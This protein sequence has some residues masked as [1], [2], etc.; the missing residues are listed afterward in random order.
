MLPV[1]NDHWVK[2]ANYPTVFDAERAKAMLASAGIP[3][4]LKNHSGG[5]AFGPGFQ[6]P[7]PG[8]VTV[9]VPSREL[10]RAWSLV[11]E[12]AP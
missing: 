4:L 3:V 2:L 10:D 8:G 11:V 7:V 1:Q 6:G 12:K 5:G 9:E